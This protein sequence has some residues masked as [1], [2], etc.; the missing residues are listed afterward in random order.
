MTPNKARLILTFL[1][2]QSNWNPTSLNLTKERKVWSRLSQSMLQQKKRASPQPTW[3]QARCA[4]A[5]RDR[6]QGLVQI[7]SSTT[8]WH[9]CVTQH[10]EWIT[11]WHWSLSVPGVL[12]NAV[13][14]GW[15]GGSVVHDNRLVSVGGIRGPILRR[16]VGVGVRSHRVENI[17]VSSVDHGTTLAGCPL[18]TAHA[19]EAKHSPELGLPSLQRGRSERKKGKTRIVM[20]KYHLADFKTSPETQTWSCSCTHAKI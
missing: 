8:A 4:L 20:C 2:N 11:A 13:Y 6:W 19:W 17:V 3:R 14:G 5:S 18:E 7:S 10:V 15:P 16:V 1:Q 9:H 12:L